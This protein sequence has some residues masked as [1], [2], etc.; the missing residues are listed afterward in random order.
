MTLRAALKPSAIGYLAAIGLY[1]FIYRN[2]LANTFGDGTPVFLIAMIA[3]ILVWYARIAGGGNRNRAL[4]LWAGLSPML[5]SSIGYLAI[6][7]L[8]LIQHGQFIGGYGLGQWLPIVLVMATFMARAWML[9]FLLIVW[10]TC[11]YVS[12]PPQ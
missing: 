8:F 11:L 4:Y 12:K 3:T 5:G 7:L 9:S 1:L 10:A 6:S 2:I